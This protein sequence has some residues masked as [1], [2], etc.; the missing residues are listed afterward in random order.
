M[1]LSTA[2]V[3]DG[4]EQSGAGARKRKAPAKKAYIPNIGSANYTL[5]VALYRV[6]CSRI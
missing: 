1:A 2:E 5:M 4:G 6:S 3:G